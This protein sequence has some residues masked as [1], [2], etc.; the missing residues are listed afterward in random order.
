VGFWKEP[1]AV[2]P[3]KAWQLDRWAEAMGW[4]LRWLECCRGIPNQ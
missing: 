3:R 2:K 1:V 4:Y